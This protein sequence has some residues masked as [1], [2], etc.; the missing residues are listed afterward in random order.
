M[1]DPVCIIYCCCV[2]YYAKETYEVSDE[3]RKTWCVM[4]KC[5]MIL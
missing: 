1:L 5:V 3:I 4:H 2:N